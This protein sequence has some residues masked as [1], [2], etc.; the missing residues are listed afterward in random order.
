M[1]GVGFER[2]DRVV[3]SE[4]AEAEWLAVSTKTVESDLRA[5]FTRYSAPSRI[6]LTHFA[7]RRP[8]LWLCPLVEGE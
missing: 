6:G 2:R 4:D 1:V 5:P 7:T 8:W 3:Q